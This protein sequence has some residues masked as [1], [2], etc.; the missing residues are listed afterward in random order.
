M[1]Y[2]IETSAHAGDQKYI[3]ANG[4]PM[5]DN[6]GTQGMEVRKIHPESANVVSH[7]Q[8]IRD[9]VSPIIQNSIIMIYIRHILYLSHPV[10]GRWPGPFTP[11]FHRKNVI[12]HVKR[13]KG[14]KMDQKT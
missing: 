7:S 14:R 4:L 1:F 8:P 6:I 2:V 3:I 13:K 5:R 11:I 12:R 10:C 9:Y